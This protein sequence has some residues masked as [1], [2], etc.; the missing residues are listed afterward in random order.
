MKIKVDFNYPHGDKWLFQRGEVLR[1][2]FQAV[3]VTVSLEN[4]KEE[5]QPLV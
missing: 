3:E 2:H 1:L 5:K 4:R